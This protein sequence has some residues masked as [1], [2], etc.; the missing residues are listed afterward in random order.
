[1]KGSHLSDVNWDSRPR[2]LAFFL[3]LFNSGATV[4]EPYQANELTDVGIFIKCGDRLVG[5]EAAYARVAAVPSVGSMPC[6]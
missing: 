4:F 3:F 6:V 1:M 2:P 5:V